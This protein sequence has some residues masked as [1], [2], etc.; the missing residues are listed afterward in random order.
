MEKLIG[1]LQGVTVLH[2]VLENHEQDPKLLEDGFA[3]LRHLS[4]VATL[5]EIERTITLISKAMVNHPDVTSLLEEC[6]LTLGAMVFNDNIQLEEQAILPLINALDRHQQC[7]NLINCIVIVLSDLVRNEVNKTNLIKSGVMKFVAKALLQNSSSGGSKYRTMWV[8]SMKLLSRLSD[9][10]TTPPSFDEIEVLREL[11]KKITEFFRTSRD[12]DVLMTISTFFHNLAKQGK[13]RLLLRE[14]K[15]EQM[16]SYG[17]GV[18]DDDEVRQKLKAL[19]TV[20]GN[21]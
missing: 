20:I 9:D 7:L 1:K 2:S 4:K 21:A 14:C 16:V 11:V 15:V 10:P 18:V 6:T 19:Y 8:V 12:R 17:L 5:P 3:A 13:Y